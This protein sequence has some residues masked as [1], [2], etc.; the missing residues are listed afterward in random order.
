MSNKYFK[1]FFEDCLD[2]DFDENDY[3]FDIF[4]LS[5]LHEIGHIVTMKKFTHK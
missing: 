5:V 1:E 2:F 3:Q 4:T